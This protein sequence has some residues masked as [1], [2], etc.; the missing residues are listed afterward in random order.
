MNSSK[1]NDVKEE[2]KT[3]TFFSLSFFLAFGFWEIHLTGT[4]PM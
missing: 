3:S 2:T 1:N 4:V